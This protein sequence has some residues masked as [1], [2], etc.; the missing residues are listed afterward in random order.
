MTASRHNMIVW[1]IVAVNFGLHAIVLVTLFTRGPA[2]Q[3]DK[4]RREIAE[5]D[6]RGQRIDHV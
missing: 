2:L 3:S 1:L 4:T 6:R 5:L